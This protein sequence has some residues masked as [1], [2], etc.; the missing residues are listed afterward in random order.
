MT[1][2]TAR[3]V[4]PHIGSDCDGFLREEGAYDQAISV[5]R[6]L[7]YELQRSMP[8]AQLTKA[9][10]AIDITL[11]PMNISTAEPYRASLESV[12]REHSTK[13]CALVFTPNIER[14]ASENQVSVAGDPVA[15]SVPSLGLEPQRIVLLAAFDEDQVN[16]VLGALDFSGFSAKRHLLASRRHSFSTSSF[17]SLPTWRMAGVK[18][19]NASAMRGPLS[20]FA[21]MA[22][23]PSIERTSQRPLRALW[24]AAHVE[25][26]GAQRDL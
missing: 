3:K 18:R 10:M 8:K 7:A 13:P 20:A 11:G 15:T 16:G 4:N 9:D 5:K 19:E 2:K 14:W 26:H 1:T 23:N 25:L 22:P 24:S 6:L 21:K 12:L 17:M